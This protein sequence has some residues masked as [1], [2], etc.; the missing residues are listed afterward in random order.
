ME[1]SYEKERE[2]RIVRAYAEPFRNV[3]PLEPPEYAIRVH[4]KL[5]LRI[6]RP[7]RIGEIVKER[8]SSILQSTD[9]KSLLGF[10]R[11]NLHTYGYI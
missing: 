4:M 7:I 2:K 10:K 6:K 9:Y 8:K 11:F 1:Q 3:E 5:I